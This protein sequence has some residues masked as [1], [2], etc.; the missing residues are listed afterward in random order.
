MSSSHDKDPSSPEGIY[1]NDTNTQ[2]HKSTP[3]SNKI[4][5]RRETD[6]SSTTDIQN[7]SQDI[8]AAV[9]DVG[10]DLENGDGTELKR[11][12]STII[13]RTKR[14]GL[15]AQLVIRIP[16]IDEPKPKTLSSS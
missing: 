16:E 1:P 4:P 15:F 11:K 3:Q 2:L 5:S 7:D 8:L 10:V 9:P 14:R 12:V 13:P 6:T